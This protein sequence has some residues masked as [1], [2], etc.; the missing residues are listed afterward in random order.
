VI[1][2]MVFARISDFPAALM[3]NVEKMKSACPLVNV[4][5][6]HLSSLMFKMATGAEALV[7][8]SGVVSML[9]VHRAIHHSACA[10]LEPQA[11]L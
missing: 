5:V 11:I 1:L 8:D 2:T 6:C 4:F 3:V 7:T 9:S 10:R